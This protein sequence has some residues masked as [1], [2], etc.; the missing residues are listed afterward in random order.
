MPHNNRSPKSLQI[1]PVVVVVE[2]SPLI[3]QG[4]E[5][6]LSGS[7]ELVALVPN[8]PSRMSAAGAREPELDQWTLAA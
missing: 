1:A 5:V 2:T 7:G 8:A 3:P 4:E 6:M